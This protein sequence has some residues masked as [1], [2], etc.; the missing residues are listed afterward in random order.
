MKITAK[1]DNLGFAPIH[2]HMTIETEDE[3][4]AL[5]GLASLHGSV[6]DIIGWKYSSRAASVAGGFL[7]HLHQLLTM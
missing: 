1:R 7:A 5:R 4:H 2:L 6:P 3:L